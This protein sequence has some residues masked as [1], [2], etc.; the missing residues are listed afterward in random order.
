MKSSRRLALAAPLAAGLLL[1]LSGPAAAQWKP[2]KP[3]TIIVPWAAGGATDQV[4]RLAAAELEP[5]LGQ[6]IV[7]VNQ[8]GGAGSIGTKNAMEA[9]RDGYT[10]TA[11]AA[12]QL[13]TYPL[14]GMLNSKV[15]D[16]HLFLS[17]TNVSIVAVNPS[18]PYQTLPQLLEAM[19]AKPVSVATAGNSSSGHFAM[20]TIAKAT[21]AKYRHV[22][23]DGGNPAV[24]ATVAGEAEVTTQLAVEMAEMIKAKRLRPLAVVA[25]TALTIE[26]FGTIPPITQFV[27]NFPKVTTGFGIFIPKGVPAEVVATV[28]KLWAEK[29][30][31]SDKIRGYATSRGALFTPL[32]GKAAYDAVWP[33]VVSDAFLLQDAGMAKVTPESIGIRR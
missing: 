25:D 23:Y 27:Q 20:E 10:W 26:G 24:V 31:K 21:G 6:K 13:G 30:E 33:T 16:F 17:V 2:A 7:V 4:T 1:A 29:I 8:P 28:E 12:K 18:S 22:T 14:L 9:P 19:K 32:F 11:G 15:D 5:A 3:I